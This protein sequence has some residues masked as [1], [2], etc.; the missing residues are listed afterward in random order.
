LVYP[1]VF[2]VDNPFFTYLLGLT[3][4]VS[5]LAGLTV[6]LSA[7][8]VERRTA[9]RVDETD[10]VVV[11]TPIEDPNDDLLNRALFVE[12]LKKEIVGFDLPDNY[13]YLLSGEWGEGK[14]SVINLLQRKL[15]QDC[16]LVRFEPWAY[17]TPNT[18]LRAFYDELLGQLHER[19]FVP[20]LK[21]FIRR[22]LRLSSVQASASIFDLAISTEDSTL[23]ESRLAIQNVIT[24]LEKRLIIVIDDLDR[25]ELNELLE[26]LRVVRVHA[27]FQHVTF[28]LVGDEKRMAWELG[29]L[30]DQTND[31]DRRCYGREYL[32]KFVQK[33][34]PLPKVEPGLIA[35]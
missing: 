17:S 31:T 8:N 12:R 21:E 5:I 30:S 6:I 11:D 18:L 9:R 32:E 24:T 1:S 25:L 35:R 14:T 23:S 19:Y 4:A 2:Q 27:N 10:H 16:I 29:K 20:Q 7:G 34:I 13:V 26:V 28:I 15:E 22:Y 3:A 33:F